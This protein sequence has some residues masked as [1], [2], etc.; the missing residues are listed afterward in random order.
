MMLQIHN[1]NDMKTQGRAPPRA[2]PQE[3][4]MVRTSIHIRMHTDTHAHMHTYTC[5]D[6]NTQMLTCMHMACT[7]MY[8]HTELGWWRDGQMG[9]IGQLGP[10]EVRPGGGL[11]LGPSLYLKGVSAKQRAHGARIWNLSQ[12]FKSKLMPWRC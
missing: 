5:M 8:I 7:H 12:G 3:A 9:N 11:G 1:D 6:T 4:T 2:G 10:R